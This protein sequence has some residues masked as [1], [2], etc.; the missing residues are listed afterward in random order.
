MTATM[1][2]ENGADLTQKST[3]TYQVTIEKIQIQFYDVICSEDL[4][5]S[6]I[7]EIF[8]STAE[9]LD[10]ETFASGYCTQIE[11]HKISIKKIH[12]PYSN[13]SIQRDAGDQTK[14]KILLDDEALSNFS[15]GV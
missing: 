6:L 14:W 12:A 7:K 3:C 1:K 8:R 13:L 15:S 4:S 5:E 10:P 2:I 9:E 11:P